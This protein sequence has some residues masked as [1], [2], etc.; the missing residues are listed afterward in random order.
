MQQTLIS[1]WVFFSFLQDVTPENF[2]AVL[3]G[4]AS[5]VKGGS[6]KVLKR[7]VIEENKIWRSESHKE[8]KLDIK[9]IWFVQIMFIT[10][11]SLS[12][13]RP[14]RSRVCVLHRPRGAWYSGLSQ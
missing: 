2:L 5:K 6:G 11:L 3:K 1:E 12:W 9:K 4:D 8:M 7:Q 13:Q 10:L 14:Q